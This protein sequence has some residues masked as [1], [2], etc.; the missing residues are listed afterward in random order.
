MADITL[1]FDAERF[2]LEAIHGFLTETHWAA[3]IPHDVVSKATNGSLCIGAL[4]GRKQVGF[5]RLVTDRATFAYLADVYVLPGH[6]G[7]GLSRKMLAALLEH[8]D[9]QGLRRMLLAARDAHGRYAKFG[10]TPL[11]DPPRFM[12]LHRPNVYQ[13]RKAC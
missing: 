11:A 13:S 3:G 9:V 8:P 6:R 5:A 2:D 1:T 12:E 10:F 4:V 7:Q